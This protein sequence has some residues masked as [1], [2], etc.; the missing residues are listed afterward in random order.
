MLAQFASPAFGGR[1]RS[2]D[3]VH[4]V[5][6]LRHPANAGW[7]LDFIAHDPETAE[8]TWAATEAQLSDAF[9][10]ASNDPDALSDVQQTALRRA[11]AIHFVRRDQTKDAFDRSMDRVAP[12][13]SAP[14]TVTELAARRLRERADEFF[15]ENVLDLYS[16]AQALVDTTRL[17]VYRSSQMP[18]LLGDSAVLS[19]TADG[20]VG[21][22]PFADAATH[23]MPIGPHTLLGLGPAVTVQDLND[24]TVAQ[25]NE[26]Q[27]VH[28]HRHVFYSPESDLEPFIQQVRNRVIS[29]RGE[30]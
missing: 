23:V 13:T 22:L 28:A 4:G 2:F 12:Q 29:D 9:R 7:R 24:D 25:L 15:A 5:P 10:T 6:R 20:G 1:I 27:I 26:Q 21:I 8:G 16:R 14:R 11:I 19:L 30:A 3:L 18:F 17:E